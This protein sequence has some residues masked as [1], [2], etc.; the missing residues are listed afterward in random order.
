MVDGVSGPG[1]KSVGWCGASVAAPGGDANNGAASPGGTNPGSAPGG[2]G[3]ADE[4]GSTGSRGGK[5]SWDGSGAGGGMVGD[6]GGIRGGGG[7][8]SEDPPRDAGARETPT[9]SRGPSSA[10]R[11]RIVVPAGSRYDPPRMDRPVPPRKLP[12]L[13]SSTK[14]KSSSMSSIRAWMP[15]TRGSSICTSAESAEPRVSDPPLGTR[16]SRPPMLTT[17]LFPTLHSSSAWVGTYPS[18]D[19]PSRNPRA[20]VPGCGRRRDPDAD[21]RPADRL[22]SRQAKQRHDRDSH[23]EARPADDRRPRMDDRRPRMTVTPPRHD[24]PRPSIGWP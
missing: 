7:P 22:R 10:A 24:R 4:S 17:Q 8:D 3:S 20:L 1:P 9:V 2:G 18:A 14:R 11:N 19:S 13:L 16:W 23:G 6:S 21:G 15:W 5:G 12:S